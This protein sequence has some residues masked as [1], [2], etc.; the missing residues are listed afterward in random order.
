MIVYVLYFR[1]TITNQIGIVSKNAILSVYLA[2]S[3]ALRAAN[4]CATNLTDRY[5]IENETP[6]GDSVVVYG[7]RLT[8]KDNGRHAGDLRIERQEMGGSPI[9]ALAECADE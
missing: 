6:V 3:A 7:A 4:N 8:F 5:L 9:E 2:K 1:T